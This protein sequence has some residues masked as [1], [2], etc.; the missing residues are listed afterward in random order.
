MSHDISEYSLR[1]GVF[2]T[3][4]GVWD[5]K[6]NR[7]RGATATEKIQ[8]CLD[9]CMEPVDFCMKYCI[10][11]SGPG[12]L[13]DNQKKVDACLT[14]CQTYKNLC[15]DICE[16]SSPYFA[17]DSEYLDCANQKSCLQEGTTS[18][19]SAC[20]KQH[21]DEILS[22][23]L[24]N[25]IP[26]SDLDCNK[27]CDFAHKLA[28]T[29]GKDFLYPRQTNAIGTVTFSTRADNT[30]SWLIFGTLSAL[31]LLLIMKLRSVRNL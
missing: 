13:Y 28:L 24:N 31:I 9:Q 5:A 15:S 27:Y 20:I 16:T 2:T 4:A 19:N 1:S 17:R 29:G 8:C 18:T 22:C 11:N 30:L 3:C 23:C 14:T 25:C 6:Q 7:Y 21:A 12:K 26:A 10:D